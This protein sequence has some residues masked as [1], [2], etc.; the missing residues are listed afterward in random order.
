MGTGLIY[1]ALDTG[2]KV[3]Y[4]RPVPFLVSFFLA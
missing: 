4:T 3:I 1:L 2:F